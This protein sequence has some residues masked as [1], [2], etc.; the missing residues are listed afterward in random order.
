MVGDTK[1]TSLMRF[2]YKVR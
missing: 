2:R 1:H